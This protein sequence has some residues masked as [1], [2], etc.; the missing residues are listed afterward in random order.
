MLTHSFFREPHT[1][2]YSPKGISHREKLRTHCWHCCKLMRCRAPISVSRKIEQVVRTLRLSCRGK[3]NLKRFGHTSFCLWPRWKSS[4]SDRFPSK[5]FWMQRGGRDAARIGKWDFAVWVQHSHNMF[6]ER[7]KMLSPEEEDE[8]HLFFC[9]LTAHVH[10][11]SSQRTHFA[12]CTASRL[13]PKRPGSCICCHMKKRWHYVIDR[14]KREKLWC[15]R[16]WPQP[17]GRFW[18]WVVHFCH[19]NSDVA[20]F[21][22]VPIG[23]VIFLNWRVRSNVDPVQPRSS[24]RRRGPMLRGSVLTSWER[25][26]PDC[27][28]LDEIKTTFWVAKRRAK[29]VCARGEAADFECRWST[30]TCQEDLNV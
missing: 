12:S 9:T 13:E 5:I 26:R 29:T 27:M 1:Y 6:E 14:M 20:E 18:I 24:W 21:A 23:K 3:L 10:H 15:F 25:W 30:R 8:V 17:F 7:A 16:Y 22:A 4:C 19:Q 2:T 11:P 28:F